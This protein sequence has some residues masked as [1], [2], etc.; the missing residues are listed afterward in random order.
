MLMKEL[1]HVGDNL[2][3]MGIR[4]IGTSAMVREYGPTAAII[5]SH[6][7]FRMRASDKFVFVTAAEISKE[8]GIGMTA[9]HGNIAKLVKAGVLLQKDLYGDSKYCKKAYCINES[10]LP[11]TI[12]LS[13]SD[14]NLSESD[15]NLSECDSSDH[16]EHTMNTQGTPKD[17][18]KNNNKNGCAENGSSTESSTGLSIAEMLLLLKEDDAYKNNL[19]QKMLLMNPTMEKEPF[20]DVLEFVLTEQCTR[21]LETMSQESSEAFLKRM[22]SFL[23]KRW[24]G[25]AFISYD[26]WALMVHN[27]TGLVRD[28]GMTSHEQEREALSCRQRSRQLYKENALDRYMVFLAKYCKDPDLDFEFCFK[29]TYT[30]STKKAFNNA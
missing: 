3:E 9:V 14:S 11:K 17:K 7:L 15:S 12:H 1:K 8:Y 24:S 20:E 4:F 25:T 13:D 26:C 19:Y 10:K 2:N 28:N 27:A 22:V 30:A 5:L 18:K 21:S 23:S 16:N 6:I 29:H